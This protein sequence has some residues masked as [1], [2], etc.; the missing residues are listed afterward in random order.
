VG[1]VGLFGSRVGVSQ[2][3]LNSARGESSFGVVG[4]VGVVGTTGATGAVG[5]LGSVATVGTAGI[6]PGNAFFVVG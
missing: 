2:R 4:V 6:F 3:F 1:V 5:L